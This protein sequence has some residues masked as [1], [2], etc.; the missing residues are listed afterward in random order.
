MIKAVANQQQGQ[1]QQQ[2]VTGTG[3]TVTE[4]DDHNGDHLD[5]SNVPSPNSGPPNSRGFGVAMSVV[6]QV[7]TSMDMVPRI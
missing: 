3:P 4:V 1:Q 6:P 2:G 7:P 5:F